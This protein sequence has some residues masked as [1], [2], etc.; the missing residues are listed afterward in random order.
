[1]KNFMSNWKRKAKS[2]IRYIG[3][4]TAR[5]EVLIMNM[6]IAFMICTMPY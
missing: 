3:I 6:S 4:A 2:F 1:M 5:E